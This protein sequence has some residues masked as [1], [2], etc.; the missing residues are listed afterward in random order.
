MLA[1]PALSKQEAQLMLTNSCDAFGVSR[2]RQTWY[3]FG[4]IAAF[5]YTARRVT[6]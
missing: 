4:S 6:V 2:G 1:L 3:H 5:R